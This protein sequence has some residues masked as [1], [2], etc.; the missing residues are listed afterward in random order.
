MKKEEL[1][2]SNGQLLEGAL[3]IKPEIYND[4]RGFF[5]E[6]WNQRKFNLIVGK[7]VEF[8]QDN[9]SYSKKGV[10]RGLHFQTRPNQQAKLVRCIKGEIFDV[11]IDIRKDSPTFSKWYGLNLSAQN[12]IQLWIPSGFAHGFYTLSEG[13]EIN[14]KISNYWA[15]ESERT[16][17]WDDPKINIK[18]PTLEEKNPLVS[19]K[20]KKGKYLFDIPQQELF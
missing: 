3:V 8:V 11:I 16:I 5:F 2:L 12:N 18:W 13:A 20:D 1:Y 17:L 9:Q 6:S 19:E 7:S 15:F 10:L 14:Y 4:S